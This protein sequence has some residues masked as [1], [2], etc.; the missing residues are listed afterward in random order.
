[1][2]RAVRLA[3]WDAGRPDD[4]REKLQEAVNL[5]QQMNYS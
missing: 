2:D 5:A 4:T 3:A 1:V